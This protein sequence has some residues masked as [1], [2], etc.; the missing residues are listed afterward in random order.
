MLSVKRPAAFSDDH[1]TTKRAR[2][3]HDEPPAAIDSPQPNDDDDDD[4]T[5]YSSDDDDDDDDDD[6][7]NHPLYVV[8]DVHPSAVQKIEEVIE[9]KSTQRP[10]HVKQ[11]QR[12]IDKDNQRYVCIHAH[13]FADVFVSL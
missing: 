13:M 6:D 12:K 8:S 3:Q 4:A 5:V 2:S 10:I 7:E 1:T 11:L 9:W